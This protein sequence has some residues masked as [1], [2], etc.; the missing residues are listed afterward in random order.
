MS[1]ARRVGTTTGRRVAAIAVGLVLVAGACSGDGSDGAADRTTTTASTGGRSTGGDGDTTGGSTDD[2]FDPATRACDQG[3]TVDPVPVTPVDDPERPNDLTLT[4]FDGT[5]IR[6]HWFPL[7]GASEAEPA[8][9]VLMGPGWGQPGD[10]AVEGAPLFASLSIGGLHDEGYNVLTWDPRGFG[11]STGVVE[12]NGPE[13][14]GRDVQLLLD[15]VAE[16]PEAQVDRPGDP[17]VGMVGFS[18]GGGIQLTTASID[19]RVDALVPGIAW[20]SL[21]T[22]LYKQ[23]TMKSGWANF[24]QQGA[25]GAELDPHIASASEAGNATGVLAE[26]D[27][28]WFRDRGVGDGIA[29]VAVPTLFLQGTVDTLFTL[30]EAMT[31]HAELQA[32]GVPTAMLWFC[33]GH[34]ACLTEA[35][36]PARTTEASFAWLDR[37]VKG[38][39]DAEPVAGFSFVD[40][41]GTAWS[42]DDVP[43]ADDTLVTTGEGTLALDAASASGPADIP[44]GGDVLSG[45]VGGLTPAPA[46]VA[47][48]IPLDLGDAE[49]LVLGAPTL[50][51]T[52][53]YDPGDAPA[54]GRPVRVF[55]QLV[56]EDRGVVVGNQITPVALDD[57][58]GTVEVDLEAIA[59]HVEPGQELTLQLVATTVAYAPG[60][61]GGTVTFDALELALP[62]VAPDALTKG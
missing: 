60:R 15:F 44:A 32:G 34:G 39:A 26:E 22:S 58:S 49:G 45:L 4:S 23:R 17:R 25:L 57:E 11:E 8:P 13:T 19:C 38:N 7:D 14:E 28:A 33:G 41:D 53:T 47:L 52:Y 50:S 5:E 9:T 55:A 18:Y 42:A 48:M 36:D 31:N 37:Y 21:E 12:I 40:Q 6:T 1:S 30:D 27:V 3:A 54:D 2:A 59:Q 24:L 46:E 43:D 56:D 62:F 35:G 20:H 51:F 61:L 10:V 16:Q 29:D